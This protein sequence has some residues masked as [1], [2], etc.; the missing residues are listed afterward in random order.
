MSL[1]TKAAENIFRQVLALNDE[2]RADLLDQLSLL[3]PSS[4]PEYVAAW[5]AEIKSRIDEIDSGRC[6]MIPA[7]EAMR[8]IEKGMDD[9]GQT[10]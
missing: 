2:D 4:D 6:K 5:K 3:E 1:M 7:D 9:D 8:M 10:G